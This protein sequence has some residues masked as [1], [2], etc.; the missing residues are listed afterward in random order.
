[1]FSK[2]RVP[3]TKG[4]SFMQF[5][6][7]Q[8]TVKFTTSFWRIYRCVLPPTMIELLSVVVLAV[9]TLP[10]FLSCTLGA[11]LPFTPQQSVLSTVE[12][13]TDK[14]R[15]L[16]IGQLNFLHTTDTHGWLG[17]HLNQDNYNAKWGDLISFIDKFKRNVVRDNDLLI[18]DTGDKHDGN[19]FSDATQPNGLNST[20]IFNELDYDLLTLG[21]HELYVE[22]NTVLEYYETVMNPK[23]SNKYVSS[24]VEFIKEDGSVVPFGSK[25]RYFKTEKHGLR[26]LALSFLFDFKRYNKRAQVTPVSKEIKKPWFNEVTGNYS[27]EEVDILLVFGHMPISDPENREIN[28]LHAKL[29]HIY[30]NTVIQYFGAHTHIRDFV[31]LD[32]KASALQSG[33]FCETVGFASIDDI[34]KESPV[35]SRKYIDFNL[36]SF[37]HHS[38]SRNTKEFDTEKGVE[39]NQRLDR[40][41]E[42]LNLTTKY[43]DVPSTYY[44]YNKPLSS[45][46]NIYHLLTEKVL[47]R[48]APE[49]SD[50]NESLTSRII[51]IN[52]GAIRY[53]LY[54]GPFTADTEYTISPF[55]NSW[56]YIQLPARLAIQVESY[57]NG[58]G[59]ILT[60]NA[61][62]KEHRQCPFVDDKTLSKGYTTSDDLGCEG[63]D[64]AHRSERQYR[65]PNVVQSVDIVDED[66]DKVDFVYV[67][68]IQPFVLQALN[69]LN[70]DQNIVNHSFNESDCRIYGVTSIKDL[71]RGYII[72]L[73]QS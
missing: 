68:F 66:E 48:L 57:L 20:Q 7:K 62:G 61:V 73:N 65:I 26:V 41:R 55:S 24:N 13:E 5:I 38:K 70:E 12:R 30:P 44:M 49:N 36:D 15:D 53:D 23:F 34:T 56:N 50:A 51:M 47:P 52:T 28:H 29:R 71:L 18:I 4:S 6:A 21:N 39:V 1:M 8:R 60:L 11:V 54:K 33:R 14:L 40:L 59:P 43:G 16:D 9:Y 32:N 31:E 35:V 45:P 72:S 46:H 58:L 10:F 64:T 42:Y 63:D 2:L 67:S 69:D 25:Y 27:R 3:W 37:L 19:G 17:S 22:D